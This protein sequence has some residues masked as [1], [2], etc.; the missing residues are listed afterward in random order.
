MNYLIES[1]ELIEIEKHEI[2]MKDD[3]KF[4]IKNRKNSIKIVNRDSQK[5]EYHDEIIVSNQGRNLHTG[6]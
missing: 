3:I 2:K 6:E 1:T 5:E 4:E